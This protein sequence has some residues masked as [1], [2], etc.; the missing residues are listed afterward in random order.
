VIDLE[1]IYP[2]SPMQK[3]M[4][5]H[6]LLD[7]DAGVYFEQLGCQLRGDLRAEMFRRAWQR[8]TDRHQVL[9]TGFNWE[10]LDR[11]MQLVHRRVELPWD[12]QDWRGLADADRAARLEAYLAADR[13]RG[14]ALDC[15]PL[16]RMALLRL[17][18][19]AHYFVWSHHHLLLDGWSSPVLLGEVFACY[20]AFAEGE[21]P[22]LSPLRPY[23]DYVAWAQRQ[24]LSRTEGYWRR[25]LKGFAAP[26]PLPAGR[27][28]GPP[29][30]GELDYAEQQ[31]LLSA[32]TTRR[33]QAVA[34]RHRL[35][36]HTLVQGAWAVLL[37][38]S[39]GEDEVVFGTTVSGRNPEVAGVESIVG[40]LVNTLATRVPVPANEPLV[41][42]LRRLQDEQA[43]ARQYDYTPLADVL[44]WSNVPHGTPLFET[45]FVFENYPV[46]R[47]LGEP[48]GSL[49]RMGLEASDVRVFER[50]NY[51]LTAIVGPGPELVLRLAYETRR[52][53]APAVARLLHRW[54]DLLEGVAGNPD[55][56][57]GELPLSSDDE[58]HALVEWGTGPAAPAADRCVHELFAEQAART[59]GAVAV[60]SGP[61]QVTYAE[62]NRR[63]HRLA[64]RL[65]RMG[66]GPEV[67]VGL[68]LGRSIE[69]AT[70]VLAVLKAGGAYLPLDP[71]YPR[72]RL[73]FMLADARAPVLVTKE[74][75]RDRLPAGAAGVV[76]LDA[77]ED[78]PDG[79]GATGPATWPD[80]LAYVIYTSG[81][82]GRPKGVMMTHRCLA[83][84]LS[85]QLRAPTFAPGRRVL[86]FTSPS[87]DVSFQEMFS[88]WLSGGTLVIA[89]DDVRADA[90]RLAGFLREQRVG[91][92]FLPYVA[93]RH[94]AEAAG[95]GTVLES[96]REVITAG[97]QLRVTPGLAA[98]FGGPD[99][100][101][102]HNQY[103]PSESHVVTAF[104]LDEPPARWP[105]LPPIGRPIANARA[106][107]LGAGMRL[108]P[109]GVPG[110]LYLGGVALGRGY[111]G[112]ADLTAE[113]FV[114]DPF[115][116]SG[117]RLYRTGDRARWRADGEL[118]FLGRVD[119]QLKV[120][121]FRVE[122]GEVE[123]AVRQH[124]AVRDAAVAAW[125]Q[126]AGDRR[127]VIYV[128][129]AAGEP[130]SV[131]EL[132]RFLGETLPDYM[133]PASVVFLDTLPLTPSG[134][135]D[136]RALPAPGPARPALGDEYVAPGNPLEEVLAGIWAGVLGVERVGVRDSFFE[137]GGDSL[138]SL[139]VVARVREALQVEIPLREFFV[140]PTV[141]GMADALRRDPSRGADVD[142]IAEVVL[143]LARLSDEEVAAMLAGRS[144]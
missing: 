98:F 77:A 131:S 40:L 123:A 46:D 35:T 126:E 27:D 96:L 65:R 141:A 83:N 85:W 1:D 45:L 95:G 114:P 49:R 89:P 79:D 8:V 93:L 62:L 139:R 74:R 12:A 129:A 39:S 101:T 125:E 19:D 44:A 132:R 143:S 78:L 71:A 58:R 127:L 16:M 118:E 51:P 15:P 17:A 59:P 102:L 25:V 88:T 30:D 26:T 87:F 53:D 34:Q 121:G 31:T 28:G 140:R 128:V 3:G 75:W 2:L 82:T 113:R 110:E 57:L 22:D 43:Q 7:P 5:F 136:R 94:L 6:T 86:Q 42:W 67:R 36:L 61:D 56:R 116:P 13:R 142:R 10:S 108:L 117:S 103:G 111:L 55:R 105:A 20:Q 54:K 64:L 106:Y 76:Y 11:P 24:D 119:Q 63:S 138:L 9:R 4:L 21:E 112:Q 90:A 50:T 23:R 69:L 48:D 14:F 84:L 100:P 107:V 66:V 60:E 73:A 120:R 41:A 137:L 122:P 68:C 37:A 47:A 81:S 134:K 124:P 91:R 104:T 135:L 18:D 109:V 70:A 32:G 72:E 33:L 38:R 144:P 97:E 115:G 92:L 52:L 99:G 29:A 133:M 80:N 130:P